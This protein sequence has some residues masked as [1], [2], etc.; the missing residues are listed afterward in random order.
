MPT[1]EE[2]EKVIEAKR[3]ERDKLSKSVKEAHGRI[4]DM[5]E[6]ETED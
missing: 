5:L 6:D 2:A 4:S 1:L 3:Q